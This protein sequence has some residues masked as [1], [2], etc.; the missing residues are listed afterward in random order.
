VPERSEKDL[1]RIKQHDLRVDAIDLH[2]AVHQWT[3]PI[4]VADRD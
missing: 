4:I 3:H 2:P 1:L